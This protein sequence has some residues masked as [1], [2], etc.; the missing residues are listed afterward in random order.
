MDQQGTRFSGVPKDILHLFLSSQI[1]LINEVFMPDG[2]KTDKINL[3]KSM[4][5][6]VIK[7]Y[8]EEPDAQDIKEDNK[9]VKDYQI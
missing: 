3:V 5:L 4:A 2:N 6:D 8:E 9:P 1:D 7:I